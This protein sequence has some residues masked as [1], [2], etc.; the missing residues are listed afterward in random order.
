MLSGRR[1]LFF[2]SETSGFKSIHHFIFRCVR[3][4]VFTAARLLVW[5]L[6]TRALWPA[7]LTRRSNW[8]TRTSTWPPTTHSTSKT[9]ERSPPSHTRPSQEFWPWDTAKRPFKSTHPKIS[10]ATSSWLKKPLRVKRDQLHQIC[11][12]QKS[13]L[14]TLWPAW[15]TRQC[16]C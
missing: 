11:P 1:A 8:C 4:R 9:T 13:H 2:S 5:T 6:L 10:T 14:R 3:S 15:P 7:R 12:I 16:N